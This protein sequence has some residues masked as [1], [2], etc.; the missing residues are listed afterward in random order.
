MG[1][2]AS[3]RRHDG[4]RIRKMRRQMGLVTRGFEELADVMTLFGDAVMQAVSSFSELAA[5]YEVIDLG[6]PGWIAVRDRQNGGVIV[7]VDPALP[8]PTHSGV[9]AVRSAATASLEMRGYDA[10]LVY[11][12]ELQ[13]YDTIN[14]G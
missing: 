8:Y 12:D 13:D 11:I 10:T 3:R 6:M 2:R 4:R 9:E 14:P 1:A 7:A 5:Q